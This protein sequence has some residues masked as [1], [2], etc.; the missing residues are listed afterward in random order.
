MATKNGTGP[1]L[2][3]MF[4]CVAWV[5]SV[6]ASTCIVSTPP[7]DRNPHSTLTSSARLIDAI[8][9]ASGILSDT[10]LE[11]RFQTFGASLGIGLTT[12]PLGYKFSVQ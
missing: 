6:L 5:S 12:K 8:G 10:S 1:F 4:V 7:D 11:A 2:G 9:G 3:M